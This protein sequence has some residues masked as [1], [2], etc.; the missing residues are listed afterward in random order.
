MYIYIINVTG[1]PFGAS[2]E[3][4]TKLILYDLQSQSSETSAAPPYAI[5]NRTITH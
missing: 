4:K 2:D 3:R 1:F 5:N